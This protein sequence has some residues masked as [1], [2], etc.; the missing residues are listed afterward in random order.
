[1]SPILDRIVR[2]DCG[3]RQCTDQLTGA[4]GL[5]HSAGDNWWA[6][7]LSLA[8]CS[9]PDQCGQVRAV[10]EPVRRSVWDDGPCAILTK[11][12][13]TRGQVASPWPIPCNRSARAVTGLSLYKYRPLGSILSIIFPRESPEEIVREKRRKSGRRLE[14]KPCVVMLD[15]FRPNPDRVKQGGYQTERE[16]EGEGLGAL[17]NR[18]LR[19]D[20]KEPWLGRFWND[21]HGLSRAG[22]KRKSKKGKEAAGASGIVEADRVDPTQ[23]LRTQVFP[24][25][26]LPTQTGPVN[27]KTG[28]PQ[29]PILSTE[30]NREDAGDKRDQ[31]QEQEAETSRTDER[32]SGGAKDVE[33]GPEGEVAEPSMREVLEAVKLMGAQMVTLTQA[34]IPLVNSSVGQVTPPVRVAARAAPE[35]LR[36]EAEVVELGPPDRVVRKVDY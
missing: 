18:R 28:L 12:G 1:M 24:T 6:A 11:P 3:V 13:S 19:L 33:C 27:N 9:G 14:E 15:R 25:Q 2:T 22:T 23:V 10:T 8:E 35:R 29:G 7:H 31:N 32:V 5:A 36:S 16:G 20:G 30:F 4:D 21:A 34:F 17:E 26:V